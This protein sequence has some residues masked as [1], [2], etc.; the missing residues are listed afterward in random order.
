VLDHLCQGCGACV[1]VCPNGA[2]R[3]PALE[4]VQALALVDAALNE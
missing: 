1:A 3:Q 4:S 2:S